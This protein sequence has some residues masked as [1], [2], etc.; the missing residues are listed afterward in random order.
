MVVLRGM[1]ASSAQQS[2]H[3]MGV[4]PTPKRP[5]DG[6]RIKGGKCMFDDAQ[7]Q[8]EK[9]LALV[10]LCPEKLQEKCFELLLGAYLDS[11]VS[12]QPAVILSSPQQ[13]P[14]QGA[15][16]SSGNSRNINV[17]PEV[18]RT[19]F[20]SIVARTKVSAAKATELFDFNVDPFIYHG[21]SIPGSSNREKMRNVALLLS[22]KSYL[23]SANWVADWKEFRAT[24]ID[25]SCWDQGNSPTIMSHE[26]FKTGSAAEGITLS[27]AG[28][29]AAEAILAKLA[30]GEDSQ[31]T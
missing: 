14:A 12:K 28:I 13:V 30:G 31:A 29:K 8:L 1:A 16:G 5:N 3:R 17:V 20:N 19:R 11:K 9:I 23:T 26:W 7:P 10:Q 4:D 25:H 6:H 18:I 15:D 2:P 22:L 24:C 21:V 27:P